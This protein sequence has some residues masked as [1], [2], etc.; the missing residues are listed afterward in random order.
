MAQMAEG[1]LSKMYREVLPVWNRSHERQKNRGRRKGNETCDRF[2]MVEEELVSAQV[3]N[4]LEVRTTESS[5]TL[6]ALGEEALEEAQK[7][8]D[9]ELVAELQSKLMQALLELEP[10]SGLFFPRFVEE[11][12]WSATRT[13]SQCCSHTCCH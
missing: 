1:W 9:G 13:E 7:K 8:E 6:K 10:P 11:G 4:Q 12:E 5:T 2:R 3:N